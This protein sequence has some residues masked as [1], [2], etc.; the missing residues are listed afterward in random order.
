MLP[1]PVLVVLLASSFIAPLVLLILLMKPYLRFLVR[2]GKVSEDLHKNPPTKVPEPVGP[3][4]FLAAVAGE[5][6][7]FAAFGTLVPVALV[8]AMS[9]AFAVGLADDLFVLGARTK[10]LLLV[11][12]AAPLV[13]ASVF[14]SDLFTPSLAFPILGATSEHFSIYTLLILVSFPVVANAFNMVDAFNGELSGFSILTSVALLSAIALHALATP[15]FAL[16]RVA[17]AMPLVAVSLGFYFFN[18]HPS[19][20]FDGDSGSLMLG[21]MFAGLAI[22]GGVEVA[23]IV[24]I[25]PAVLN[26]F[27]ILSSVRGFVERRKMGGRPTLIGDD[28]RVYASEQPSAPVTLVRM[29]LLDGPLHEEDLVRSVLAL[30]SFSAGLSVLTSLMTWVL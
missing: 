28:G 10:P 18:K 27:Y 2:K 19:K 9:V 22:T 30:T 24:A 1:A 20:A 4:L 6:V 21:T 29:I 17:A 13:V 14:Q 5:L 12:A 25:M 7:A 26:S 3:V 23:A 15:G 11:L 8:G 16:A